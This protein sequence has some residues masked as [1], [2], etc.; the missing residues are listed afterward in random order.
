MMMIIIAYRLS[1]FKI[2][3]N[4]RAGKQCSGFH[5][6]YINML[7]QR[8]VYPEDSL[9]TRAPTIELVNLWTAK[10]HCPW[11]GHYYK[12]ILFLAGDDEEIIIKTIMMSADGV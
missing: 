1:L 2:K 8:I 9:T 3:L 6:S 5:N 4:R 7:L 12:C 10:Y 11:D